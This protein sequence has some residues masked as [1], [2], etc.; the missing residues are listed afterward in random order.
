MEAPSPTPDLPTPNRV[1]ACLITNPRSGRGGLNLSAVL[2]V[3][4]KHG[5]DVIIREKFKG[6]MATELARKAA[7][8][9]CDVVVNCGGDGTLREIIGGLVG[10]NT[11]VGCLPGGTVNLWTKEMGISPRLEV[12]ALQLVG[13][14]RHRVDVGYL[15]IN[16]GKS[17]HFLLMAG[18]GFDGTVMARVSKPLK[19]RI[20]ELAVGLAG[21]SSVVTYKPVPLKVQIG[22]I[23][24][25]GHPSQIII[26]NTRQYGGF[27]SF[28]PQA[29]IDD[30]L[31][32]ICLLTAESPAGLARQIIPLLISKHPNLE[33]AEI[34][35]S[36]QITIRAAGPI[37]LQM[38]G[39]A[40]KIKEIVADKEYVYA[41]SVV[42]QG[43]TVLVPAAY[44][45]E[46][47]TNNSG[48]AGLNP[49]KSI[50]LVEANKSQP[51][52]ALESRSKKEKARPKSKSITKVQIKVLTVGVNV[53]T[54]VKKKNGK[55][56]SIVVDGQTLLKG[57]LKISN[58]S[59]IEDLNLVMA[60][61]K[62]GDLLKV[63]GIWEEPKGKILAR[64]IKLV[65]RTN[66]A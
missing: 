7:T 44:D 21:L 5:W 64:K 11:A 38:D 2:P 61:L 6:G 15:K 66:S 17:Y 54:G 35:R 37:P 48:A 63:K 16:E 55:P 24:W 60:S 56:V 49:V 9:G 4:E 1:R 45:G 33:N 10:T 57:H 32:D 62:P 27:T 43:V 52:L 41:F 3:L 19:N 8:E 58:G 28:T 22:E 14:V 12:A 30:G 20:G 13:S 46:L 34:Y 40:V 50:E 25:E 65:S 23:N 18:L 26:G 29:N 36:A 51:S 59:N 53:I 47:F 31:L 39:G 42:P